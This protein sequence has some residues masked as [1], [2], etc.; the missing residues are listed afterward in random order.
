M[1][2]NYRIKEVFNPWTRKTFFYPQ[3]KGWFSWY[4]CKDEWGDTAVYL[5]KEE[6]ASHIEKELYEK[7][8]KPIFHY[9]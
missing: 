4:Y 1:T 7:R 9:L 2:S 3:Y 6:A 8:A 5:S